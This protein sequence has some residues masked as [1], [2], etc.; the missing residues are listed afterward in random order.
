MFTGHIS[1][2]HVKTVFCNLLYLGAS[3]HL[4]AM[5]LTSTQDVSLI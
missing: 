4:V 2:A 5:L 1:G 3:Y